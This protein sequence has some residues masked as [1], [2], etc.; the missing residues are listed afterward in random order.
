[1]IWKCL[2]ILW[3][4]GA[5]WRFI[6]NVRRVIKS[7]DDSNREFWGQKDILIEMT[8]AYIQ[9]ILIWP[10]DVWF[11]CLRPRKPLTAR[12]FYRYRNWRLNSYLIAQER[13]EKMKTVYI[14]VHNEAWNESYAVEFCIKYISESK[15]SVEEKMNQLINESEYSN[16]EEQRKI[17]Q[18]NFEKHPDWYKNAQSFDSNS[19]KYVPYNI[20]L[21]AEESIR[22]FRKSFWIEEVNLDTEIELDMG[23][24]YE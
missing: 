5:H 20:D 2:L 16:I 18:K 14:L 3:L 1:M 10:Y 4:I 15:E 12:Q 19:G 6:W 23:S 9:F 22:S 13:R 17:R 11:W 24:Y 21:E 7:Y 8:K